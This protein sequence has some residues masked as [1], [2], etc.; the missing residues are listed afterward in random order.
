MFLIEKCRIEQRQNLQK[1]FTVMRHIGKRLIKIV[2][3]CQNRE[4][5]KEVEKGAQVRLLNTAR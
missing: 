5:S 3:C 2:G 4:L 1:L